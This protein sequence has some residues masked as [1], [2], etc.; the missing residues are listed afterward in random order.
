MDAA[1]IRLSPEEAAL[2]LQSDWILT[3]NRVLQ[4]VMQLLGVLQE[5][6]QPHLIEAGIALPA[7]VIQTT[8][9]I[10]KGENYKGLPYLVLDQP[11]FFNKE[12]V[13]AIRTLFWWGNFF[14][15]TWQLSGEYKTL[16][17][18]KI[19]AAFS[20][21]K[22]KSFFICIN[23]DPWEH[24]FEAGNF[25]SLQEVTADRFETIIRD[26]TFIKLS[27]KVSLKEWDTA[28]ERLQKIFS[29]YMSICRN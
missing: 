2:V 13:F 14:S 4:K 21:L 10:S 3:K 5:A 9:K 1:K 7:E 8:A 19:I 27:R 6:Q 16:Y 12:N 22:E 26:H 24:H 20:L 18:E 28:V 29:V 17:A 23:E 25:I 15:S 11:R